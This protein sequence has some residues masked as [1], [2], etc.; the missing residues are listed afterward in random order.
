MLRIPAKTL[1]LR[2]Q[3]NSLRDRSARQVHLHICRELHF[4]IFSLAKL[5][6]YGVITLRADR[7]P[8]HARVWQNG[9]P[10]FEK[11]AYIINEIHL[12]IAKIGGPEA[13]RQW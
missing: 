12:N 4:H 11:D 7:M 1:G 13:A 10:C 3:C 5:S 2:S 6:V 8:G 9:E